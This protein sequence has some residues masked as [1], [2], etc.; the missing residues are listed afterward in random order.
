MEAAGGGDEEKEVVRAFMGVSVKNFRHALDVLEAN[1]GSIPGY[2]EET[3]GIMDDD[4]DVLRR[5]YLQ[6]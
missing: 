2:L 5:R 6:D 3:M 4:L 1:Y